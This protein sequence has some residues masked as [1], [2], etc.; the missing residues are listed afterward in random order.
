MKLSE[1]RK[2]IRE[3]VRK[4]VNEGGLDK[5]VKQLLYTAFIEAQKQKK[6]QQLADMIDDDYGISFDLEPTS[7]PQDVKSEVDWSNYD[8]L[9]RSEYDSIKKDIEEL[10]KIRLDN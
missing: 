9:T 2:L 1:F 4:V 5:Q 7:T 3:E 8:A 10:L 6:F